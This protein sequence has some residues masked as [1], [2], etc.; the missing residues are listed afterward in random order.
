MKQTITRFIFLLISLPALAQQDTLFSK[1]MD[2]LVITATRTERKLG[3][4]AVPTQLISNKIIQQSGSMR[5]TD[6][7]QEQTG[8]YITNSSAAGSAGGG[9]FGNGV[10]IQGLSPDY[11]LIL[12]DGEPVIGR[13]GGVIDLSRLA[14]A[15]IKKIEIVKGPSSSLYGSEAMGGVINIITEQPQ[16]SLFS[17][18][19]RYGRFHTTDA[20]LTA[21]IK[22][23]KWGLQLFGN[24]NSSDGFDLDKNAPGNTMDPF[25]N[26]TMQARFIWQPAVKTK[27][28]LSGRYYDQSQRN[29]YPVPDFSTNT[30]FNVSGQ[31]GTKDINLNPV[32]IQQFSDQL[33]SALR[34]YFS[35]YQYEQTLKKE[36]DQ[37][38]YYHDFFQQN[39]YRAEDQTDWRWQKNNYL[40]LGGGV[41]AEVLNTTRYTGKRSNTIQ[42][43]FLQNEWRT[44]EKL[45]VIGGLRFDNNTAYQSK[46]SP[47]L[48]A[49][50]KWNNKFRINVSYGA[51][52][53]APDFR[54][55]FLNFTNTAA[56]GYMIYGANEITIQQLEQQKQ[57]G[58]ITDILPRAYQLALLKPEI[59]KGWNAGFHFDVNDKLNFAANFFR[60]DIANLIQV[61]II[62]HR[63]NQ[64]P[65]Y[66]Y[67]NVS[68]AFTQGM[69]G[70]VQFAFSRKLSVQGGYQ[71][72]ITADKDVL[73]KIKSGN[74]YARAQ[75]TNQVYVLSRNEYA[76]LPNRSAHMANLKLFYDDV[77]KGWTASIRAIYRSRW[78]TVDKDGNGIINRSDEFA[79][80][81]MLLNICAAKKIQS[82][83]V[84]AGIDNLLNY[85]D[86]LNLPGQPG[87]QPYIS[88]TYLF[89]KN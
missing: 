73:K 69:E 40:S 74:E 11:T 42:Y 67:F 88:F 24:R 53:K 46:W 33:R 34:F 81:F 84:Q 22:N 14:V 68:R 5:L 27:L 16:K 63:S 1:T 83:S 8:L 29:F 39:F 35:R 87:I 19:F 66:S 75:N 45:T 51:G 64:A 2:E 89:I 56:G 15:N 38:L 76:G 43:G 10:Q 37:S 12:I 49:Q 60:N 72:L 62:A 77:K 7:L 25:V 23:Q 50:Y 26:Y 55:L 70:Q 47:K 3:N 32:I 78:G 79:P 85:K 86:V 21:A 71:F 4:V 54:Q 20:N 6:V 48:A 36:T 13:Q 52:F 9:V 30:T 18:S 61:D 41:V 31:A 28:N 65:V 58:L 80:G 82:F 44:N 17:S 59:S 57:Q